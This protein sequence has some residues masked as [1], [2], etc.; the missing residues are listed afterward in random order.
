MHS[1]TKTIAEIGK[2]HMIQW[3]YYMIQIGFKPTQDSSE[4]ASPQIALKNIARA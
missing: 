4:R 1:Y 3:L 2:Y